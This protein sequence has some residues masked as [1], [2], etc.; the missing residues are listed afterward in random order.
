MRNAH[1]HARGLDLDVLR[2]LFALAEALDRHPE[3]DPDRAARTAVT[4]T[5]IAA[6]QLRAYLDTDPVCQPAMEDGT[7]DQA[8]QPH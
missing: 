3:I 7:V 6:I 8:P 5:A 2:A 1:D 4:K